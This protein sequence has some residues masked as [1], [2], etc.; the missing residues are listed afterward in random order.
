MSHPHCYLQVPRGAVLPRP[1]EGSA[2]ALDQ[3]DQ[4]VC[5]ASFDSGSLPRQAIL[6]AQVVANRSRDGS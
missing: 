6:V 5:E 3:L 2:A 1:R 4:S